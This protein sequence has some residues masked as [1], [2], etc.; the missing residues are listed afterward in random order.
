MKKQEAERAGQEQSDSK[1]W[2][3]ARKDGMRETTAENKAPASMPPK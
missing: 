2:K 1:C 3:Q